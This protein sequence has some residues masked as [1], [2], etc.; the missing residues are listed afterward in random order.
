MHIPPMHLQNVLD[1]IHE[2]NVA[3]G[4][5]ITVVGAGGNRDRGK[6]PLMARIAAEASHKVILTSDNPQE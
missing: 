3:G 5:I 2:V 1:T 4:E 6:R